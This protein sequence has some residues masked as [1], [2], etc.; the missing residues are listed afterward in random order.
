M[1]EQDA[2]GATTP[3]GE[4]DVEKTTDPAD[5]GSADAMD[6]DAVN[7]GSADT[8]DVDVDNAKSS[9]MDEKAT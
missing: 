9:A 2:T 6:T 4:A 3:S 7:N 1:M 5:N 8:M